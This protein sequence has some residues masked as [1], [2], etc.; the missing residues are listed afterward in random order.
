MNSSVHLLARI[1]CGEKVFVKKRLNWER[2][3]LRVNNIEL[4]GFIKNPTHWDYLALLAEAKPIQ[5]GLATRNEGVI[6]AE[7]LVRNCAKAENCRRE[8]ARVL[9][10]K[11]LRLFVQSVRRIG[12]RLASD[13]KVPGKSEVG[14]IRG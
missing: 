10:R 8:L 2:R 7:H 13:V 4:G 12:H 11:V 3:S 6:R 14:L 9:P 1:A 5:L